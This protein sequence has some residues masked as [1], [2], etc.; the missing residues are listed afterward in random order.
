MKSITIRGV[1]SALSSA[2]GSLSKGESKSINQ[3]ILDLLRKETGLAKAKQFTRSYE[4]LDDLFGSWS[5][6]DYEQVERAISQQR[7]I[8]PDL[9]S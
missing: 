6:Q 5:D 4:D 2:L 7:T 8:D 1:D 9:W 3:I